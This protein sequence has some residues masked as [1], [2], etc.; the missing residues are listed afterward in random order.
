MIRCAQMF[1]NKI[2]GMSMN[3]ERVYGLETEYSVSLRKSDGGFLHAPEVRGCFFSPIYRAL[4]PSSGEADPLLQKFALINDMPECYWVGASAG[5]LYRDQNSLEYAT[6]ECVTLAGIVRAA[7]CGD[8]I[9][10]ELS[11]VAQRERAQR[12]AGKYVAMM[13]VKNN[14]DAIGGSLLHKVNFSGSHENY[15]MQ[16]CLARDSSFLPLLASGLVM[17]LLFTGGGGLVRD[18]DAGW[19]Y[20]ISPRA[21]ATTEIYNT[22]CISGAT[23][24]MFLYRGAPYSSSDGFHCPA[25]MVR[26]HIAVNDSTMRPD[27]VR[28]RF[29]I[30]SMLLRIME[31]RRKKRN[32]PLLKHPI[33]ALHDFSRDTTLTVSALLENG[34]ARTLPEL[35]RD[36]LDVFLVFDEE[37]SDIFSSEEK[38]LLKDMRVILR[39]RAFDSERFLQNTEWGLKFSLLS[40]YCRKY[41]IDFGHQNARGFDGY[42]SNIGPDGFYHKWEQSCM[43]QK[44]DAPQPFSD[45][46]TG[47]LLSGRGLAPRALLRKRH[48]QALTGFGWRRV[49]EDWGTFGLSNEDSIEISNPLRGEHPR[50]EA[51][52]ALLKRGLKSEI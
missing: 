22:I 25:G 39:A 2:K 7:E 8:R 20:V 5:K 4:C 3:R 21:L 14:S 50:I 35:C 10:W 33:R 41:G 42:Y 29:G 9:V 6:P 15:Q 13:I 26:L 34:E 32:L 48:L 49:S 44:K 40:A 27:T 37:K 11:R 16:E 45:E 52:I 30:V 1:E 17:R 46:E 18:R 38:K 51:D 12:S 43:K 47:Q 24:P 23:L 31:D 36:W 19:Q 28:F